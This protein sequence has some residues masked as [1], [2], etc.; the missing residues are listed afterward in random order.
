MTDS[1]TRHIID[2]SRRGLLR[3]ATA[4]AALAAIT[5][6][7]I[8][9]AIAQPRF[10]ASPFTTGIA[11]GDPWPDGVVIWT[12]LA[13]DPLANGGMRHRAVA[14][15]WEVAEDQAMQRVVAKGMEYARP[16]LGHSVHAEVS[17]LRPGRPYFYRFIAG[18][19]TSETGRTRTAPA[20]S[21][22]P[23]RLRFVSAGCQHY[24]SGFFTLWQHIAEEADL[25]F[26]FHYGDYIYEYAARDTGVRRHNSDEI[27]SL[28]DYRNRYA[29][30]RSDPALRAAHAAHP[31]LM[32]FDDHEVDNNW[33]GSASE[34]DGGARHPVA[35]PPEIF[36]LRKQAA[37]QAWYEAMPVRAALLPRGPAITAWRTLDWGRLARINVLDTRSYRDD[38][39]CGD[40]TGPA[41]PEVFNPNAQVLGPA[42]EKWLFEQL[43]PGGPTWT[44][45]A[46]QV[47]IMARD[48]GSNAPA[49]SMD[50]WD[51]Y[52]AARARLLNHIRDAGV[53]NVAV[54]TGDL[55]QALA[56]HLKPDF[57]DLRSPA[58]AIEYVASSISSFNGGGGNTADGSEDLP[59]T[60]RTL[61][62]NPHIA[63][64]NNRRGYTLHDTTSGRMETTFRAVDYVKREGAP[65]LDKAKFVVEAGRAELHRL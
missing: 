20:P 43:R 48:Y 33:A 40:T 61:S 41:C 64:F 18:N 22:M 37:F 53:A 50:K 16:E 26:V 32:S 59:S 21:D 56:A 28:D 45:L 34:E 63:W 29:Q 36:A 52:P 17:G 54:L 31:F 6:A 57:S 58:V 1:T 8:G 2:L 3:G 44:V 27:Y 7:A 38:Q 12:R 23:A 10:A 60:P 24:E 30:Y 19:E 4:A 39:P 49:I 47:P 42:Q 11:S 9:P 62:R 25:D 5:P 46:Q 65:L 51:A 14:V 15:N 13:P 35:V 55:H